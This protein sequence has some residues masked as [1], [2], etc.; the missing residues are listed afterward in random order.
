MQLL[1]TH[2]PNPTGNSVDE[3][4]EADPLL[5]HTELAQHCHPHSSSGEH[6]NAAVAAAAAAAGYTDH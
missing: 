4:D 5:L 3:G 1:M 2:N 6:S